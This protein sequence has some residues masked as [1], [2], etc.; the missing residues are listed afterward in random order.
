[1][2]I[3]SA[4]PSN[5]LRAADLQGREPTVTIDAVKMEDI[6]GDHKLLCTFRQRAR[7]GPETR[8]TLR[9]SHRSMAMKPTTGAAVR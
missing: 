9:T 4:F 2:N 8:P 6:G 1:M 5:Y 7:A 3:G